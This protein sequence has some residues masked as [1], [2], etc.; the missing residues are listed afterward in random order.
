METFPEVQKDRII[1]ELNDLGEMSLG[2]LVQCFLTVEDLKQEMRVRGQ[3]ISLI[4]SSF[5]GAKIDFA[6]APHPSTETGE[7]PNTVNSPGEES[8]AEMLPKPNP[9]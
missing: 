4:L 2:V 5:K 1:V 9:E 3:I 8:A 6:P 7:A